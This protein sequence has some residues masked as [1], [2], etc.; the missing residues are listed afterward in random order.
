MPNIPSEQ[1]K[2]IEQKKL[3]KLDDL[4]PKPTLNRS[5][6]KMKLTAYDSN[7]VKIESDNGNR[8]IHNFLTKH[9]WKLGI[10]LCKQYL[11]NH[12]PSGAVDGVPEADNALFCS[13]PE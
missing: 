2:K 3:V 9:G 8:R 13:T 6:K 5:K 10:Y 12:L 11:F 4:L 1:I 7:E